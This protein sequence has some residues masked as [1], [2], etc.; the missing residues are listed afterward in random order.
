MLCYYE[1]F[2]FLTIEELY[3]SRRVCKSWKFFIDENHTLFWYKH[4][5][6]L[7]YN[8][9]LSKAY[10]ETW[11]SIVNCMNRGASSGEHLIKIYSKEEISN[12]T[13]N[14]FFQ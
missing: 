10:T 2:D 8:A 7:Y 3:N 14:L 12:N 5:I 4:P 9:S 13:S 6:R 1:F 11:L